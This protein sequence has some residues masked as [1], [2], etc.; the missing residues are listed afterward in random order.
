MSEKGCNTKE[1][2]AV[3]CDETNVN[4]GCVNGVIRKL[5]VFF[6]KPLHWFVCLLH[7]NELSLKQILIP[8][9]GVTHGPNSFA[10]L[11]GKALKV[12]NWP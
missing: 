5:E 2:I 6:K 9:D 12:C 1:L 10:G 8:L 11:I 4:T 7:L 3:G